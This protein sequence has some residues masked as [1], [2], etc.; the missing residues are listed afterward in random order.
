MH[1]F[2]CPSLKKLD[3]NHC[4]ELQIFKSKSQKCKE[5]IPFPDQFLFPSVK[6]IPKIEEMSLSSNDVT[7]IN[8]GEYC[9]DDLYAVKTLY[10]GCF[11]DELDKLPM[12]FLQRFTNLET[13]HLRHSSFREI[14]SSENVGTIMKLK[15][16]ILNGLK[17]LEYLCK[18]KSE[19]ATFLPSIETLH[20]HWCSKL[21]NA[22]PS[23]SLRLF[24]N[25]DKLYVS[26]CSGLINIITLSAA[27]SFLKLR[28]LIIYNCEM[29][30]EIVADE[31]DSDGG[32]VAFMKLELLT[33]DNLP[34]LTSFCKESFSFKFP[35]LKTLY[36]LECPKMETFSHG[37]LSA[38]KLNKVLVTDDEWRWEGE[39]N[40]TIRKLFDEK[41]P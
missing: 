8:N 30:E 28:Q 31:D 21:K 26:N 37:T 5:V 36:V 29:V 41:S 17:D 6:V 18:E 13:L 40:T 22:V 11:H 7:K 20:V 15:T 4:H 16:L 23:S 34:R 24:Q 19:M 35:L 10:L 2:L 1:T 32:E 27:R 25:L 3:V 38:P 39:L 33:L 12:S 9:D 14:F